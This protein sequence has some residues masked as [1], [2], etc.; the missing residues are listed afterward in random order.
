MGGDVGSGD[1]AAIEGQVSDIVEIL[2]ERS[3]VDRPANCKT[4]KLGQDLGEYGLY[5]RLI[6]VPKPQVLQIWHVGR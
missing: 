3:K 6:V 5:S 1:V 4:V 2:G